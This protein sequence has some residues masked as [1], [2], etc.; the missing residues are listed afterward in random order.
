[1]Y[2]HMYTFFLTT[3]ED[4]PYE[5]VCRLVKLKWILLSDSTKNVLCEKQ[6]KKKT[7]PAKNF[8]IQKHYD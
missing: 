3:C 5:C 1:M 6:T 4:M 2:I 8:C 7:N